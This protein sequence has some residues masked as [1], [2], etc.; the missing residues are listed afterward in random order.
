MPSLKVSF[1]N[2][3]QTLIFP[4]FKKLTT[5][6]NDIDNDIYIPDITIPQERQLRK[7]LQ[8]LKE[9]KMPSFSLLEWEQYLPPC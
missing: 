7:N 4:I 3:D 5:I 8:L 9:V 2:S 6:G 1:S